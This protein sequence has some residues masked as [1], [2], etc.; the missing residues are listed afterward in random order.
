VTPARHDVLIALGANI[1]D[2]IGT[3]ARAVARLARWADGLV[4]S[5][6]FASAPL[7]VVDQPIF[8]NM[9]VRGWTALAPHELL[10]LAMAIEQALGRVR[11]VRYGPR[12]IDID[13]VYYGDLRVATPRLTIPHPL[14]AE[15]RFVMA[16]LADLAPDR[17]DPVTGRTIRTMLEALPDAGDCRPAGTLDSVLAGARA[18]GAAA[19]A[20]R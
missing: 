9:A 5:R 13:I 2:R 18:T 3:L 6:V 12:P 1:G 4:P 20:R 8:L 14:R 7:Y 19:D 17:V 15:R 11:A 16:P 10:D